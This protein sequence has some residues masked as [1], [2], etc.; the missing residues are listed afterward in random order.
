MNAKILMSLGNFLQCLSVEY[1]VT[2]RT[3]NAGNA[4]TNSEVYYTIIGTQGRTSEHEA[5]NA[6]ND[7]KKGAKET[8]SWNDNTS[9]GDF[10]CILITIKGTDGWL[11]ETVSVIPNLKITADIVPIHLEDSMIRI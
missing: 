10:I 9:I 7:R 6:G 5:D 11:F 1:K 4:E 8:W 3:A 2:I